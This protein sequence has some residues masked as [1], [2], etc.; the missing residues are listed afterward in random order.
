MSVVSFTGFRPAGLCKKSCGLVRDVQ[1]HPKAW[2]VRHEHSAAEVWRYVEV[3]PDIFVLHRIHV[4][5]RSNGN[6]SK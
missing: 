1:I 2:V 4:L 6:G 5:R 3:V